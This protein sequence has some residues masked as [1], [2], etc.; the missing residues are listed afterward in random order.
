MLLCHH[1]YPSLV[2]CVTLVSSRV[3][4]HHLFRKHWQQHCMWWLWF[5]LL[6]LTTFRPSND[7]SIA[8]DC[9][10]VVFSVPCRSKHQGHV[11]WP[12]GHLELS[13]GHFGAILGPFW[14]YLRLYVRF[15]SLPV[16][17]GGPH[18]WRWVHGARL[19]LAL[20]YQ[21]DHTGP[22]HGAAVSGR[23][24]NAVPFLIRFVTAWVAA[25]ISTRDTFNESL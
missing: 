16:M 15:S 10:Y 2:T 23:S 22:P 5:V 6:T 13:W 1:C 21:Y 7:I 17:Q 18:V 9:I 12:Q 3:L 24:R 4:T 20:R 8:C 14:G 25:A 19:C 11:V